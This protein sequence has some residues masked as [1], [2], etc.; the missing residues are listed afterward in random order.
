[1]TRIPRSEARCGGCDR[2]LP[3]GR[4]HAYRPHYGYRCRVC[5]KSLPVPRRRVVHETHPALPAPAARAESD[6]RL[7]KQLD[8]LR[9]FV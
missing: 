3:L 1:M 5:L 7:Q 4:P 9:K 6:L 2:L 8:A